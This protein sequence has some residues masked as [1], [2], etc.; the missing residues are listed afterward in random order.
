MPM[1]NSMIDIYNVIHETDW[2]ERGLTLDQLGI[3]GMSRDELLHFAATGE[4]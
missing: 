4:R 3:E 2:R 1:T